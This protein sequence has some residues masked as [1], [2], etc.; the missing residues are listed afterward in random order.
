MKKLITIF[1]H[2]AFFLNVFLIFLLLMEDRIG[3]LSPWMQAAG[4]LHP[5]VLHFPIALWI[6]ALA[7]EWMGEKDVAH[8]AWNKRIEFLLSFTAFSAAA[9]AVFGLL[10]YT[11]GAYENGSQLQWHKWLGAIV[12]FLALG[13]VWLRKS[14]YLI[15]KVSL[16]AGVI[17]VMIAGHL[18]AGITHGNDFLTAPF[19]SKREP[20]ADIQKAQLFRDIIQPILDEKCTGCHNPNKA[21]GGLQLISQAAIMKGGEDGAVIIPGNPDSSMFYY[22][23]LLPLFDEKHMPPEGKPQP[24]QE[25]I[26]LIHWW[27][28]NGA[29]FKKQVSAVNTPDSIRHI[30]QQKYG[31]ASPLDGINIAFANHETI[32]SLNS[33]GRNVRQISADKPYIDVFLGS[34]KEIAAKEWK[35]LNAIKNQIV[36]I[37]CSHSTLGKEA[38]GFIAGFPH[39]QKLHLQHTDVTSG[40]LSALKQLQYLE[41]INVSGTEVT[42]ES[43]NHLRNLKSLK[44]VYLYESNIPTDSIIQFAKANKQLRVGY[45]PDLS[46][47]SAFSGRLSEPIVKADSLL[48]RNHA[49]VEMSFRLKGVN[50]HY[51]TNGKT[52][53]ENSPR[54][55]N[56]LKIDSSCELKV[57]AVRPG[58][59]NSAVVTNSFLRAR[60]QPVRAVLAKQPDKRY[61]ARGD[62]TLID[63]ERGSTSQGDG[64]YLGFEGEDLDAQIDLGSLTEVNTV[65][66]GYLLNHGGYIVAPAK[67]EIWG[68]VFGGQRMKLLSSTQHRD[69]GFIA[70]S[71]QRVSYHFLNKTPVRFL[72]IKMI[73]G[74]KLPS[75]HPAKGSKSWLFVDEV[76]VN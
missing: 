60:Y 44:K 64:K 69:T 12:S 73:N 24:D 72:R 56:I 18:G 40:Q 39:L 21:K 5:M 41:Y 6:V 53:D 25:E 59:K 52:P 1:G 43:L 58:W 2:A 36:S 37:D 68:S 13:L 76:V 9:A 11:S 50:I 28:A 27:I 75:W 32:R 38:V 65:A 42:V 35:E 48:F 17:V 71:S 74:K 26:A 66:V 23:L 7:F 4:R 16:I 49:T 62:S 70:G 51:T 47:D 57:I 34:R 10:L 15:Y 54:Y 30:I 67:V 8:P 3:N 29:D 14:I 22:F 55:E 46:S 63:M 45:T 19:K 61:A 33:T 31:Q 20:L